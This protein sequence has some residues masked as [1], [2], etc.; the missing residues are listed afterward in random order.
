VAGYVLTVPRLGA[1]GAT[2]T[3]ALTEWA[4]ALAALLAIQRWCQAGAGGRTLARVAV[5][6]VVAY[7]LAS[8]WRAPGVWLIAQLLALCGVVL[9][10]M[11]ALGEV[12]PDDVAFIRSLLR[13]LLGARTSGRAAT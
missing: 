12:T 1:I 11:L 6:S 9:A 7:A 8:A 5:T 3:T 4:A 13:R 10:L 2:A